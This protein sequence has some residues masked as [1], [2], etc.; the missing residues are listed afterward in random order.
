M[1]SIK[2]KLSRYISISISTLLVALFLIT[3]ISV[4]SWISNEFDKAM[5]TKAGL[6]ETLISE[7]LEK[8]DFNFSDEFMPEFSGINDPEY[9]QLWRDNKVFKR[10]ETLKLFDINELP[11]LDLALH[12][13]S[14]T[15][16]TLPD[17]RSGRMYYIKFNPQLDSDVREEFEKGQQP[18]ALAYA[19][20]NEGLNQ[21]LWLVDIVFIFSS[22]FAVVAVR[23]IVFNVV[24]RGLKPLDKLNIELKQIDLNSEISE[25]ST[26]QL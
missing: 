13:S 4:D 3:D 17:G 8:V 7:D 10:S 2:K 18:M 14:I 24:E 16:I 20:S 25:I 5:M 23:V 1:H 11:K 6:L 22:I 19:T 26:S 21:V 15:N 12:E 9:F